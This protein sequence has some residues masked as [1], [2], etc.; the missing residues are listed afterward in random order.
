MACR[1]CPEAT[2]CAPARMGGTGRTRAASGVQADR[3]VQTSGRRQNR[4]TVG[5][6]ADFT[7]TGGETG[8]PGNVRILTTRPSVG[9][10]PLFRTFERH[11]GSIRQTTLQP[12]FRHS[13]QA[14]PS[15]VLV[16]S[17]V[18]GGR[19]TE[20]LTAARPNFTGNSARLDRQ[21]WLMREQTPDAAA[22]RRTEYDPRPSHRSIPSDRQSA[23]RRQQATTPDITGTHSGQRTET[24][25]LR[26]LKL[27]LN[28]LM[29]V[30]TGGGAWRRPTPIDQR[31]AAS[32]SFED[33]ATMGPGVNVV[34]RT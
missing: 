8:I 6:P 12:P 21:P 25:L 28:Q 4:T 17:A 13:L 23:F 7:P 9:V 1:R 34:I 5:E 16:R 15:D 2:E 10:Q 24:S 20:D 26:G 18:P 29:N 11:G 30:G 3:P 27:D 14:C 32:T 33:F 19:E 22:E 31:V